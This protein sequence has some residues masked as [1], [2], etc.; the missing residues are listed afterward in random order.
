MGVILC[1]ACYKAIVQVMQKCGK[2]VIFKLQL[3]LLASFL[4]QVPKIVKSLIG[5]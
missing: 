4:G 2:V 5:F 1:R 3:C